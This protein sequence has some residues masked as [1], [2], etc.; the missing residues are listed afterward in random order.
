MKPIRCEAPEPAPSHP[1][2]DSPRESTSAAKPA[3][4]EIS[5]TAQKSMPDWRMTDRT[6][7]NCISSFEGPPLPPNHSMF[8]VAMSKVADV[9]LPGMVC[10]FAKVA[11]T[12]ATTA[13][14]TDKINLD[15][16][17]YSKSVFRRNREIRLLPESA[18]YTI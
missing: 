9:P 12:S 11:H 14:P 17:C 4:S 10:A 2:Q 3:G 7:A 15:K 16:T 5:C 6:W 8:H 1:C 18:T 13:R